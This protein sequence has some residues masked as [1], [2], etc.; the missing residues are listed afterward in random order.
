MNESGFS[1]AVLGVSRA[2]QPPLSE[3]GPTPIDPETH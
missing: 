2:A 1:L 3:D